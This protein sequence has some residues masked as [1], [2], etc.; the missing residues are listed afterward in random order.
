M[1]SLF[2]V[3]E[4]NRESGWMVD[5]QVEAP[6]GG[7]VEAGR[8]E[9]PEG[10]RVE[11]GRV[12]AL[13]GGHVEAPEGGRVEAPAAAVVEAGTIEQQLEA[14]AATGVEQQE[15]R[16]PKI[17]DPRVLELLNNI[18]VNTGHTSWQGT[19]LEASV[20]D[21]LAIVEH[22]IMNLFIELHESVRQVQMVVDVYRHEATDPA[23]FIL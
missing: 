16:R 7:H 22:R 2:E 4:G 6:E 11:A 9:A 23:W 13:E 17:F 20:Y 10:G 19:A 14:T 8:V 15:G 5:T 12:E 21:K 3:E 18:E 1:A